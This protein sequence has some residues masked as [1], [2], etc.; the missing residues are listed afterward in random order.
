MAKKTIKKKKTKK[1]RAGDKAAKKS[2]PKAE[3][4][5][6]K[7]VPYPTAEKK[8]QEF[9]NRLDEQLAGIGGLDAIPGKR[10]RG[11]PRKEQPAETPEQAGVKLADVA[12]ESAVR[13]PFDLWATANSL[14]PLKLEDAEAARLAASVKGLLEYY[15]PN[16][17]ASVLLWCNFSLISY[18]VLSLRLE[19]IAKLK[20]SKQTT[21]GTPA[22][23]QGP[24]AGLGQ[25]AA[26]PVND[27][28][29]TTETI[30]K[31][32]I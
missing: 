2:T 30:N 1:T 16:L 3:S 18:S 17:P 11:R 31:E 10:G 32:V 8:V 27:R 26:R 15:T 13:L 24:A 22:T 4:E 6:I 12:I 9:E 20:R 7:V 5:K 25:P 29:P 23:P 14:P 28:F 21:A 19:M